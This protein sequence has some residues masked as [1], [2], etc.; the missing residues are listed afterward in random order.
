LH[1]TRLHDNQSCPSHPIIAC[2]SIAFV[3]LGA[4]IPVNPGGGLDVIQPVRFLDVIESIQQCGNFG[5]FG[6]GAQSQQNFGPHQARQGDEFGIGYR[7]RQPIRPRRG[8]AIEII[9]PDRSID[10]Y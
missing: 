1:P 4:A 10:Q 2:H 9:D 7:L 8:I 5:R 3:A 6:F